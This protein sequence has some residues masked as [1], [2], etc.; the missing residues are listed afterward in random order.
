MAAHVAD[1]N[2]EGGFFKKDYSWQDRAVGQFLANLPDFYSEHIGQFLHAFVAQVSPS[3]GKSTFALKIARSMI[4]AGLIDKVVIVAP[5]E[6]IKNG[7]ADD[8]EFVR[9]NPMFQLQGF[10]TI[11]VDTDLR[12]NYIGGLS[13]VHVVVINYQS[14]GGMMGYF[15]L[16]VRAGT[17]LLFV[18]DEV[19][20]GSTGD[21]DED[22][23]NGWG[24]D[25]E[26]VRDVAHSIVCMTGTPVRTDREKVPYLRYVEATYT[27][28]KTMETVQALYVKADFTFS[29]KDAIEAGV[30]RRIIFHRQDPVVRFQHTKSGETCDFEGPL[31][32]VPKNLI[33]FAKRELFKP[34]GGHIDDM[35]KLAM[36]DYERNRL[37]G[38]PDAAILVVVGPT[39]EKMGYNPL[40]YVFDR[41]RSMFG[42]RAAAVESKDGKEARDAVKAFK[43]GC[44]YACTDDPCTHEKVR[45]IVAKDMI[46]EGTSLP[47]IRTVVVLRDIRSQVRFEQTV[48]RATRNRSDEVSQDAKVILFHLPLMMK[49]AQAIEDEIRMI[50]PKQRPRCPSPEC[51]RELEFWPRKG[52]PCPFC[53]YEPKGKDQKDSI[54]F[55]WLGSEFGNETIMQAGEEVTVYDRVSR[56]VITKLGPNPMYGG[57]HGINDILR[58]A[59]LDNLVEFPEAGERPAAIDPNVQMDRDWDDGL[60]FCKSAARAISKATGSDWQETLAGVTGQCKRAAG[61]GRDPKERV[62]R[63]YPDPRGT[64]KKFRDA[65]EEAFKRARSRYGSAA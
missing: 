11:R 2:R 37:I 15:N 13:N 53:G 25:M 4:E 3:G 42:E 43:K 27:N 52:R 19:H 35:L 65:A 41:I 33:E 22:S 48:H 39:D 17:R 14:L 38:D 50:I 21:D 6:T 49:F 64:F 32:S 26:N 1:F 18:F 59:H 51:G 63:D 61:M 23:A 54:D 12:S 47:R 34:G 9:M 20:H 29:Y 60:A 62:K 57:R 5:R 31:S 7:F 16:L 30:A 24:E 46:T 45:W 58:A 56:V 44:K 55:T 8:C 36:E 10:E 40:E 28:P